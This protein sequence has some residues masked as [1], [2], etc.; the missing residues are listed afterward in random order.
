MPFAFDLLTRSGRPTHANLAQ[1]ADIQGS[2]LGIKQA[3]G[4]SPLA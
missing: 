2:A 1:P 4:G 3:M